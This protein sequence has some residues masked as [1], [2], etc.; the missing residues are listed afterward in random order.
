MPDQMEE[1]LRGSAAEF[2]ANY[3]PRPVTMVRA[4]GD[5]R[6]RRAAAAY[7]ALAVAVFASGG[8]VAYTV[9]NH[10]LHQSNRMQQFTGPL[11]RSKHTHPTPPSSPPAHPAQAATPPTAVAVTKSGALVVLNPKTWMATRT[12]VPSGVLPDEVSVTPNGSTVYYAARKGCNSEVYSVPTAGGPSTLITTGAEPA[13]SPDGTKLAVIREPGGAVTLYDTCVGAIPSHGA[14]SS[15][16]IR[17]LGTGAETRHPS[18]PDDFGLPD[19]V[20]HLSWSPDGTRLA[21]SLGGS[22]DNEGWNLLIFDPARAHYYQPQSAS[23]GPADTRVPVSGNSYY[24]EAVYLPNGDLLVNRQCCRGFPIRN[25]T[26]LIQEVTTSGVMV[27]QVAIGWLNRDHSSFDAQ[28]S[29]ILYLSGNDLFV[30]YNGNR[31]T[32]ETRGL[33]AAAWVP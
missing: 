11:S 29:W 13:V 10:A 21:M 24:R 2:A 32:L 5:Q 9:T 17:D 8:G 33:T 19:P 20:L 7:G 12:L 25:T 27:H 31:P 30:S 4:R 16:V 26:S 15:L 22:Q 1:R 18:S 3:E 28:G 23:P 6:R 14:T